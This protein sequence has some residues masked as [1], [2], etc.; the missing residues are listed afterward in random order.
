MNNTIFTPAELSELILNL[1]KWICPIKFTYKTPQWSKYWSIIEEKREKNKKLFEHP[2][3]LKDTINI[4]LQEIDNPDSLCLLDFG[5]GAGVTV[6]P[7][8]SKLLSMG[9]KIHYHA[10]D[11]SEKM[12]QL[13]QKNL[14]DLWDNLHFDYTLLDFENY[15]LTNILVDIRKKYGG[16]PTIAMFLG[17]TIGNF[18]SM[19]RIITNIMNSIRISDRFVVQIQKHNLTIEKK[20]KELIEEYESPEVFK[21]VIGTLQYFGLD[22]TK[23]K[24]KAIFNPRNSAIETYLTIDG[25]KITFNKGDKVQT[26]LS[27]KLDEEKSIRLFLNLDYRI[28]NLRTNSQDTFM[29][30]MI[31]TKKY[32]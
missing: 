16:L 3:L 7:M 9:K 11:I 23:W 26:L 18:E 21:F 8:I 10:F 12:V 32:Y 24:H 5:C 29:E 25:Y 31:A 4:Y 27:K 20:I 14:Q 6:K 1:E 22:I 19:E 2:K 30:F 17:S 13:A 15:N 28:A